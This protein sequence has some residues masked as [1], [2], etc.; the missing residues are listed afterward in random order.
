MPG[1]TVP[2]DLRR[3]YPGVPLLIAENGAAY[4]TGPAVP[5]GAQITDGERLSYLDGHLRAA[6]AAIAAGVDL[7]DYYVWSFMDNFEWHN[8]YRKRFGIVDVDYP[9]QQRLP[10]ENAWWYREV[11]RRNGFAGPEGERP[12]ALGLLYLALR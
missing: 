2:L 5:G 8:G 12:C 1:T 7:R 10:K 4:P 11:I 6:H 3:D 9:T